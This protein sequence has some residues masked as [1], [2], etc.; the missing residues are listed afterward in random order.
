MRS[1]L[2]N[3]RTDKRLQSIRSSLD[4]LSQILNIGSLSPLGSQYFTIGAKVAHKFGEAKKADIATLGDNYLVDPRT[5]LI[6]LC[7]NCH[8]VIHRKDPPFSLKE[9]IGIIKETSKSDLS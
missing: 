8:T 1:A 5:D 3:D 6:P 9:L 7:P 2:G 4:T